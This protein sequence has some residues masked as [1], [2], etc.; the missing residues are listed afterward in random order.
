MKKAFRFWISAY[1]TLSLL[2]I[3][4]WRGVG[5]WRT[6]K[7]K[8]DPAH[9]PERFGVYTTPR[10][11][12]SFVWLHGASIGEA[13]SALALIESIRRQ[14]PR[15]SFFLTVQTRNAL[16]AIGP[17]LPPDVSLHMVPY[18]CPL[19]VKRFLHHWKPSAFCLVEAECWPC[20]WSMAHDRSIPLFLFNFHM[21]EKSCRSWLRVS[22]F[23][24]ALYAPFQWRSTGCSVSLGFFNRLAPSLSMRFMPSLKYASPPL[25]YSEEKARIFSASISRPYWLASCIHAGEEDLIFDTHKKLCAHWPNLLLFYAPRHL[26][27]VAHVIE[28]AKDCAWSVQRHS[29]GQPLDEG[30][31][32][33]V[34][35]TLGELGTFYSFC[36]FVVLGGSFCAVGGHNIIEPTLLGCAVIHGPDMSN[37]RD[38]AQDFER[39]QVALHVTSETL[40]ETL[41][42]LIKDPQKAKDMAVQGKNFVEQKK[43]EVGQISDE[44]ACHLAR[45]VRFDKK[46]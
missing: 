13:R 5:S 32:M 39:H 10:P 29:H 17:H 36:P 15:V 3:P 34:I 23:F 43:K 35:D 46:M 8:E 26:E 14:C 7:G 24:S 41:L 19:Y 9:L 28:K 45:V 38:V 16:R 18:D 40:F 12:G 2:M 11:E 21:S 33:Y 42:R 44:F 31:N 27:R 1:K 22:S 20:L 37:A 30:V 6:M 4:L 25:T